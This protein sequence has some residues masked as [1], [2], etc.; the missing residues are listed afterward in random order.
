MLHSLPTKPMLIN[1]VK[2]SAV[3]GLVLNAIN[4]GGAI[5]GDEDIRWGM[6][7]LNFCVPFLV[8]TYSA[9]RNSG[10][11]VFPHFNPNPVFSVSL[12]DGCVMYINPAAKALLAQL[13]ESSGALENLLPNDYVTRLHHLEQRHI[14]N[15]LWQHRVDLEIYEYRVHVVAELGRA[16]IYVEN[17]TEREESKCLLE[18]QASHDSITQLPNRRAL[19]LDLKQKIASG[20]RVTLG[21]SW[22]RGLATS[23][24]RDGYQVADQVICRL[25][26]TFQNEYE[27]SDPTCQ[28]RVYRFDGYIFGVLILA[29]DEACEKKS[30]EEFVQAV[31]KPVFVGEREFQLNARMGLV[32]FT[33]GMTVD[34]LIDDAN[35]ALH[36]AQQSED[37]ELVWY[38]RYLGEEVKRG[39]EMEEHLRSALDKQELAMFFQ[40]QIRLSDGQPIGVEAL[41]RWQHNGIFI[42]PDIFIPMAERTGIIEALGDWALQTSCA[43]WRQWYQAGLINDAFTMAV[44]VSATEF[45]RADF[46]ADVIHALEAHQMPPSALELEITETAFLG[47]IDACIEVMQALRQHGIRLAI[48][49]FGTGYSSLSYLRRMPITQLKIDR[50]FVLNLAHG[51]QDVL[52][53]QTIIDLAHRLNLKVIT[54]GIETDDQFQQLRKLGSDHGQGYWHSKPASSGVITDLLRQHAP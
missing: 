43:Q 48:D 33:K 30:A 50:S 14:N 6:V 23:A 40:P 5:L 19:E 2:I 44:N 54:E 41:M 22:V 29:D 38:D 25:A 34:E 28:R 12:H 13:P 21:L 7:L 1:A 42:P 53:M 18:W 11:E 46:V 52:M 27:D 15:D 45:L 8:S 17:V 4:Q 20:Q 51:E 36:H 35:T 9:V 31:S 10:D 32:H 49:D 37:Q 16:H 24:V 47:D 3:V 26:T 39:L